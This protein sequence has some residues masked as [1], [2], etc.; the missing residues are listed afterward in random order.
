MIL[1]LLSVPIE[2]LLSVQP[3][4]N[5]VQQFVL[6][7]D[8]CKAMG[9]KARPVV[10]AMPLLR[11]VILQVRRDSSLHCL[12]DGPVLALLDKAS[13]AAFPLVSLC[14]YI[15]PSPPPLS[16]LLGIERA[17]LVHR[18]QGVHSRQQND[19]FSGG[20]IPLGCDQAWNAAGLRGPGKALH[21]LSHGQPTT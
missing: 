3:L 16:F 14:V 11:V 4:M 6:E 20:N 21:S 8:V 19:A 15:F 1:L 13:A 7:L 9:D 5:L 2:S 12:S 10:K 17:H 18:H